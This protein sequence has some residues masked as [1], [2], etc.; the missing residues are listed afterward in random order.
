MGSCVGPRAGLV[1]VEKGKIL[2]SP[3]IEP[4]TSSPPTELA[5]KF[6]L[7]AYKSLWTTCEEDRD[8]IRKPFCCIY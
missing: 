3:G 6:V 1:A 7:T 4:L 8:C 5:D 2:P